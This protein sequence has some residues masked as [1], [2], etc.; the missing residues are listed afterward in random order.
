M[1]TYGFCADSKLKRDACEIIGAALHAAMPDTAVKAALTQ[2]P[3]TEGK[4]LVV[5]VGKAAWRMAKA[6]HD[7]LGERID[8]GIVITKHHHTLTQILMGLLNVG[9]QLEAVEEAMPPEEWREMMP[10]EMR[11]PMM[12]LVKAVKK[13]TAL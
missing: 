12:L 2:L 8:G 11:R 10:E 1:S 9:F 3:E 13:G 6:A 4:L 7:V 5:A